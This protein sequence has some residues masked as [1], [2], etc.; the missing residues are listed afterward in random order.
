MLSLIRSGT[1]ILIMETRNIPQLQKYIEQRFSVKECS[2]DEAFEKST[3][4]FTILFLV[5]KDKEIIHINDIK[6]AYL[7]QEE[8]DVVLCMVHND[9]KCN[10]VSQMRIAPRI[11]IMRVF[12]NIEKVIKEVAKDYQV[13]AGTFFENFDNHNNQGTIL[14]LTEQ[15]LNKI[16]GLKD[17]YKTTLFIEESY[18][19]LLKNLRIHGLK[20][21]NEGL[22]NR[23][24]Y[25]LEIKIYDKYEAYMLHYQRLL[26]IIEYL[27]LG[28]I[29]GE[30]WGQDSAFVLM[31]VG[32]YRIRFF[33]FYEPLYIKKILLGLE[34]LDDGTRIVDYDVFYK[35]KKLNW[36]DVRESN[37]KEKRELSKKY[38]KL[39]FEK[40]DNNQVGEIIELEG[41]I[42][43]TRY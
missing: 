2:P 12:G 37:L 9:L 8:S 40:L 42:L 25:E 14:A 7:I 33:T 27:E 21:L 26:K 22:D 11:I 13:A 3:E 15:P 30:S 18:S 16:L 24:W 5:D 20:Y 6:M 34:Y 35:R 17:L 41:Q 4:E 32:I 43:A 28:I 1:K 39:I 36:I 10:L 23:D 38:K 19:K 29:L 31:S